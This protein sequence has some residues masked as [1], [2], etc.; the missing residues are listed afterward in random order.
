V[1]VSAQ[2]H[3]VARVE[4]QCII[5][6]VLTNVVQDC[7]PGLLALGSARDAPWMRR[8]VRSS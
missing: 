8:K 5:A 6:A 3:H 1:V 2:S 7:R 4:P